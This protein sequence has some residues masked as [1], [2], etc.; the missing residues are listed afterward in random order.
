MLRLVDNLLLRLAR[1]DVDRELAAGVPPEVSPRHEARARH[2]VAPEIRRALAADWEHL[3]RIA[4]APA[5]GLSSRA[6][7][8]RARIRQ[9]ETEINAMVAA[10][11]V[12]G[13]FPVRGVAI[14]RRLLNDGSGPVYNRDS[15]DDLITM[16]ALARKH[17]N[18]ERAL[19]DDPYLASRQRS[20]GDAR[21]HR[22]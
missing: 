14:A 18:P 13:P 7:I 16:V 19:I 11:R 3:L 22:V 12:A 8:R 5:G 9:A 2:L 4:H 1:S 6:P 21:N 10:L 15:P 20:G 17:L